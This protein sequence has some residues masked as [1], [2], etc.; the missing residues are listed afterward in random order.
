VALLIIALLAC[1]FAFQE[2]HA[3]LGHIKLPDAQA[4][5][6]P[7]DLNITFD[8]LDAGQRRLYAVT[9][10]TLDFVY[11]LVYASL[12]ALLIGRLY[13]PREAG[14]RLWVPLLTG[15]FDL[16]ENLSLATLAWIHPHGPVALQWLA[17][18]LTGIK[19]AGWGA[20]VLLIGVGAAYGLLRSNSGRR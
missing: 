14:W 19:F 1:N 2:R 17:A 3:M 6:S 11:P 16:A 5:R 9:E 15:L 8:C 12:F 18:V 13:G 20:S 4:L 7:A 10:V